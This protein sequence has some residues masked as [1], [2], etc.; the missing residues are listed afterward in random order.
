M[1]SLISEIKEKGIGK[2]KEYRKDSGIP[3]RKVLTYFSQLEWLQ[4]TT[5]LSMI[6]HMAKQIDTPI[7]PIIS[8]SCF[9]PLGDSKRQ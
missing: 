6:Y 1:A 5:Y 3:L 4:S 9:D 7:N 2:F 8:S